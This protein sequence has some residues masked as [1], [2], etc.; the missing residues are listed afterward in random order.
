MVVAIFSN[1]YTLAFTAEFALVEFATPITP[2]PLLGVPSVGLLLVSPMAP[3]QSLVVLCSGCRCPGARRGRVPTA[4]GGGHI[5][6]IDGIDPTVFRDDRRLPPG[7]GRV[8]MVTTLSALKTLVAYQISVTVP[9]G[10][11]E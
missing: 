7:K 10:F 2:N 6:R 8:F 1:A 11:G 4:A 5:Q 3:N 9:P